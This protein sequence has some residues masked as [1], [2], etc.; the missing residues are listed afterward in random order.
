VAPAIR[1]NLLTAATH[2]QAA[3]FF[4]LQSRLR[5]PAEVGL[6]PLSAP[7]RNF[8]RG[9]GRSLVAFRAHF[10]RAAK[11]LRRKAVSANSAFMD[12]SGAM[13]RSAWVEIRADA[14][15]LAC[16]HRASAVG[17]RG[18]LFSSAT[19][20]SG[21]TKSTAPSPWR[22]APTPSSARS[23]TRRWRPNSSF[24]PAPRRRV[25]RLP[26]GPISP[27]RSASWA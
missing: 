8:P 22:P 20:R 18:R 4:P 17:T 9:R 23:M 11:R 10:Q 3:G 7:V 13:P 5:G 21:T 15:K 24:D 12:R 6:P 27:A 2:P 14:D 1:P 19:I 25:C 16:L 26:P